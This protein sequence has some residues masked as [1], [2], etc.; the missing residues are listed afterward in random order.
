[1]SVMRSV[2]LAASDSVGVWLQQ[3]LKAARVRA[4]GDYTLRDAAQWL[5]A[6]EVVAFAGGRQRLASGTR[7]AKGLRMLDDNFYGVPQAI[8]VPLDQPDRLRLINATLSELR[9]SGFLSDSV[10]RS[11]IEG[12]TVAP[13]SH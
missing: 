3:R 4:T 1:M 7:D 8:A 6:G 2:L 9:A 12:L 10:A 5:L 11:G 13:A